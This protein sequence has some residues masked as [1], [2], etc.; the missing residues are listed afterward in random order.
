MAKKSIIMDDLTKTADGIDAVRDMVHMHSGTEM[1]INQI[2]VFVPNGLGGDRIF[3]Y[4]EQMKFAMENPEIDRLL[5]SI[6]NEVDKAI[7]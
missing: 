5:Q 6:R 1:N 4:D 3:Q 7:K 2:S